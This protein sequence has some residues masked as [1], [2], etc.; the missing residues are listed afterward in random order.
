MGSL[1]NHCVVPCIKEVH[2]SLQQYSAFCCWPQQEA[3][4]RRESRHAVAFCV[5]NLYESLFLKHKKMNETRKEMFSL[6]KNFTC[7]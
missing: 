6:K 7:M 5:A 3:E 2:I 1:G 4:M